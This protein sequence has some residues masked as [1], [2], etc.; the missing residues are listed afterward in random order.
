MQSNGLCVMHIQY[1]CL[2]DCILNSVI[3]SPIGS[4]RLGKEKGN[5]KTTTSINMR[6]DSKAGI[7]HTIENI[8]QATDNRPKTETV[9]EQRSTPWL[10]K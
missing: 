4:T 2:L 10:Q 9:S 6:K 7:P 5:H 8:T 1:R 3:V